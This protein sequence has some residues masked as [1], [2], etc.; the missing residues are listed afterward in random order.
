MSLYRDNLEDTRSPTSSLSVFFPAYNDALS[1]PQLVADSFRLLDERRV[2]FE[3][4]VI[5]DGSTDETGEVLRSLQETYGSRLRVITHPKNLGYGAAL[6]TGFRAAE[7]E[8]VFY[9]DGDGQ[10][11]VNELPLLLEQMT[12]GTG[13]VNG[14]KRKRHDPWYRALTGSAYNATVRFLFG[15]RL[16]DVDCDFRLIRR[17]LLHN[18]NLTSTSGTICVELVHKLEQTGAMPVQ[19][20]VHHYR[21]A[22]GKSQ[23]FRPAPLFR[24][25]GQL[26]SLYFRLKV[27]R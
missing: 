24:T 22:H 14:L 8:L 10:Y 21:R 7:K 17:S 15:I 18:V 11:D 19:V 4:I 3:V 25:F 16:A 5:N 26:A 20:P 27:R 9:T 6:Q 2:D 13:F 12:P 1:L 23:F